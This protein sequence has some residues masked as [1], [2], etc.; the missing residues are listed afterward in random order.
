MG[1]PQRTARSAQPAGRSEFGNRFAPSR[2]TEIRALWEEQHR[3]PTDHRLGQRADLFAGAVTAAQEAK[4]SQ[5]A[6]EVEHRLTL[7]NGFEHNPQ[8]EPV[9]DHKQPR[10]QD[11]VSRAAMP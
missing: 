1:L 6:G 2:P 8:L 11:A 7:Q 10:H 5:F 3:L 4:T 9:F